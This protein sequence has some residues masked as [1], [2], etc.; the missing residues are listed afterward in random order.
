MLDG[1]RDWRS[2]GHDTVDDIVAAANLGC[3]QIGEGVKRIKERPPGDKKQKNRDLTKC[4][5]T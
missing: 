5:G 3:S 4:V 2:R 1:G